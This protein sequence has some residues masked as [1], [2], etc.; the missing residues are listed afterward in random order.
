MVWINQVGKRFSDRVF[1]LIKIVAF[2]SIRRG[3]LGYALKECIAQ[4]F[5]LGNRYTSSTHEA[6]YQ[7][8]CH[9][10]RDRHHAERGCV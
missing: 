9:S 6:S 8:Q 4:I 7:L 1:V 3:E 10:R 2:Q 5:C